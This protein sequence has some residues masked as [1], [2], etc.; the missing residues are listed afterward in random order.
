MEFE[1]LN[2]DKK[3]SFK[4]YGSNHLKIPKAHSNKLI[5]RKCDDDCSTDDEQI[6]YAINKLYDSLKS[7][8]GER[9]KLKFLRKS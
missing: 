6:T 3:F 7:E 9:K 5:S 8:A 2:K 1:N 4:C